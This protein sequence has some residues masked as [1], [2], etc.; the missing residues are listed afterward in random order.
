[1]QAEFILDLDNVLAGQVEA[2][3][4]AFGQSVTT[5]N[6][7]TFW[8]NWGVDDAR[9]WQRVHHYGDRFYGEMVPVLPWAATLIDAVGENFTIMSAPGSPK[10]CKPVDWSAKWLW[11]S[12]YFPH[13]TAD[14]LVV[15]FCKEK[16]A[17]GPHVM[18]IDDSQ[19]GC[20]KFAA[21]GGSV[22]LF[23]QLWNSNKDK[24]GNRLGHATDAIRAHIE[25]YSERTA[26][27]AQHA[28][29]T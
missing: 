13:V 29:G 23:P 25:K 14:R 2:S 9:F 20:E 4:V 18:L 12:K 8:E 28:I 5:V 11:L 22:F 27:V 24:I 10:Q 21:A 6:K 16:L 15:G 26:D 7:W 3:C 19:D 1:M 17:R